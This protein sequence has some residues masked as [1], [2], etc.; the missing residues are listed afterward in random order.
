[1]KAPKPKPADISKHG[2]KGAWK[3]LK[4]TP[5]WR[6]YAKAKAAETYK[7]LMRK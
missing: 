6:K 5:A 7:K 4:A 1:M 2:M 3:K